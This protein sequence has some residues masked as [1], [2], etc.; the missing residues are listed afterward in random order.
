M[1][2]SHKFSLSTL[3]ILI[4]LTAFTGC[5]DNSGDSAAQTGAPPPAVSVVAVNLEPIGDVHEFAGRTG[6]NETVELRA[7][8]EGYLQSSS[9][10]EGSMVKKGQKLFTIDPAPFEAALAQAK[11]GLASAQAE[12]ARAKSDLTRG[13]ELSPKGF[14]SRSDLDKLTA[15]EATARASVASAKAQLKSAQINLSYTTIYAPF[16][17]LIGKETYSVGNLVGPS[18]QALAELINI[19]PIYVSF[20]ANEKLLLQ[21]HQK[22]A[23]METARQAYSI[24][25]KLP[26]N[27]TY[28][29]HGTLN[30]ADVKVDET[31][32]TVDIRA[33][34]PNP[35]RQLLPGMYVTIRIESTKKTEM[36]LIPQFAVQ[37]NQQGRFVLVVTADNKVQSRNVTLGRRIGPMWAVESGLKK[38][39]QI[40]VSGLQKVR[41]NITV[42]PQL[43]NV[44]TETGVLTPAAGA[45]AKEAGSQ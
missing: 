27:Q 9:F 32:G 23:S 5:S 42:N 12:A 2:K 31:T 28:G 37:E 29:Q 26:N 6:A 19:D 20:Q 39:E 22:A 25:L 44:N 17:G 3:T 43:M 45:L 11:A 24:T 21:Y 13:R 35:T 15:A 38:G 41:P 7:R 14:I 30:F 36:P 34:F 1:Q 8:V 33:E 18:T 16:S 10:T 4:A 40:I